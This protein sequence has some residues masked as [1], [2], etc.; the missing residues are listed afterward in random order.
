M[1]TNTSATLA[2]PL[3][4]PTEALSRD[5]EAARSAFKT[6]N[7]DASRIAHQLNAPP[8]HATEAHDQSGGSVKAITFGGLDGIL[9]SFAIVAGAV[10]AH[11]SPVAILAMGISNVLADALS[12]GAGE[13]LSSRAYE[14]YVKKE[15]DRERWEMDNYP[16]GEVKEMIEL[17]QHRGMSQ[18]DA[19]VVIKTMAKY[20][21]FFVDIMMREELSLPV[22][23]DEG[24]IESMREGAVMFLSFALFGMVPIGGFVVV[25]L[26][27]PGLD[28]HGLFAVACLVTAIALFGLGAFK[29]TFHDKFYFR[30][31]M[32]TMTLGGACAAVAFFVGRVVASWA[33]ASELF[34]EP[35]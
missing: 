6:N 29:A 15:H 22:P 27:L 23:S 14:S 26:L 19:E 16:E 2:A 8:G 17:F 32:E 35:L 5:L 30:A 1:A 25:P 12:M 4:A 33:G 11:L 31:G 34:A 7:S 3:L 13:Y 24:P 9:T 28:E 21:S 18:P 20:K 10:G